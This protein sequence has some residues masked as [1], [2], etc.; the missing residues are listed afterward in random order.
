MGRTS[1]ASCSFRHVWGLFFLPVWKNL[2]EGTIP[3]FPTWRSWSHSSLGAGSLLH[4]GEVGCGFGCEQRG[5]ELGGAEYLAQNRN[6]QDPKRRLSS[7]KECLFLF[8]K[9]ESAHQACAAGL[10]AMK[11]NSDFHPATIYVGGVSIKI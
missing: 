4:P 3:A 6:T 1:L 2:E 9:M 10:Y 7:R 5:G 8:M 11:G